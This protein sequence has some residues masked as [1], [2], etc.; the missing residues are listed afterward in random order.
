MYHSTTATGRLGRDSELKTSNSGLS[1]LN[2]SVAA[3]R[4]FK[5]SNGEWKSKTK[6]YNAVLFGKRA[7]GLANYL[8]KGSLVQVIGYLEDQQYE[9]DGETK[10]ITKLLIDEIFLLDTKSSDTGREEVPAKPKTTR[11]RP[12]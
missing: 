2:F 8:K 1:F 9:K 11:A 7:E 4:K 6:W 5:D 3:D 12:V 10:Y